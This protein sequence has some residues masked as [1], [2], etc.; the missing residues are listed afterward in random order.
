MPHGTAPAAT[1]SHPNICDDRLHKPVK[2]RK[3]Q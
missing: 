2:H 1:R 3:I